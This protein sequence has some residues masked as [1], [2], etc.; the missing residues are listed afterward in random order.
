MNTTENIAL[1][2]SDIQLIKEE[3][4]EIK[5]KR[6]PPYGLHLSQNYRNH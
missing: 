4:L 6:T 1:D 3:F 5:E 2:Q